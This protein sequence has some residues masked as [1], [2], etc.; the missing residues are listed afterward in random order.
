MSAVFTSG[1]IMK[2]W[3]SLGVL[4]PTGHKESDCTF[5]QQNQQ[6]G[7]IDVLAEMV[8]PGGAFMSRVPVDDSSSLSL[9]G[10]PN[11]VP[12][13]CPSV[14]WGQGSKNHFCRHTYTP[15]I[16][17]PDMYI[18]DIY[19]CINVSIHVST[20]LHTDTRSSRLTHTRV[21]FVSC[22]VYALACLAFGVRT[23]CGQQS[24]ETGDTQEIPN[25]VRYSVKSFPKHA[26]YT[27]LKEVGVT[28]HILG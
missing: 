20:C 3:G 26:V 22:S 21:Y 13:H 7:C 16:R 11:N 1:E 18:A 2:D 14:A 5:K 10:K 27:D 19:V 17:I 23:Y 8:F 28:Q 24:L 4:Q 9:C 6:H 25:Y 12:R 15:S